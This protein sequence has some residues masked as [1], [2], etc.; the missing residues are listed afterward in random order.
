MKKNLTPTSRVI[1]LIIAAVLILMGILPV[2]DGLWPI[3]FWVV[4]AVLL[5]TA[6]IGFCPLKCVTG[7]SCPLSRK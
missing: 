4:A 3:L 7:G 2:A 6:A 1:R 5:L